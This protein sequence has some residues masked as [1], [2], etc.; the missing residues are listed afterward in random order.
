MIAT[1]R[2]EWVRLT[3]RRTVIGTG[4]VALLFGVAG[5]LIVL[6]AAEPAKP[7]PVGALS[8]TL[9]SLSGSGGGTEI[10][11][12]ATA[13]GGT[14][15]FV[16]FTALFAAEFSRGTYRTML[17]RQPHRP[18]LLAGKLVAFL[19]FAAIVLAALEIVM[20]ITAALLASGFDV[21]TS[22]WTGADALVSAIGDYAMALLW[23]TGYAT[24]GMAIAV[25]L[26]SVPVALAVGIAWAGPFEHLIS[27]AWEPARRWFPGLL[28][29]VV[30]SG[31]IDEVSA[32]RAIATVAAYAAVAAALVT[33]RF[34]RQD[35]T[36]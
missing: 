4:L 5:P 9:E 2:A 1:I 34:S 13:F 33:V 11:R 7:G 21:S 27:D 6:A 3:R 22:S 35:I 36:A 20:W 16:L 12:F 25:T 14:L 31:G 17:L 26:R 23:V 29:E 18:A 19:G 8:P 10:F 28:L 24:F 15:V 32:G 30:G